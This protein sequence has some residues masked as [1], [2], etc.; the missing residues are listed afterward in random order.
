M[1]VAQLSH[2]RYMEI[3]QSFKRTATILTVILLNLLTSQAVSNATPPKTKCNIRVDDP[4]LSKSLNFGRGIIAIKVNA[5]SRCN[6]TM[7]NLVLTVV[8]HK[9]GF[10]FDHVV[11]REEVKISGPIYPNTLIKNQKTYV[12]CKNSKKSSYYGEAFATATIKGLNVKTLHVISER[13]I[14]FKCGN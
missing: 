12:E 13:T 3:Q 9:T 6:K 14:R 4:H 11:A 10:L 8:I 7:S 2:P 5:R 1:P